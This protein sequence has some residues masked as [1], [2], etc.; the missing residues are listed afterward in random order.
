MLNLLIH[1][2]VL[3]FAGAFSPV[4]ISVCI[5]LLSTG[6]PLS[7]AIAYVL[8]LVF[9]LIVVGGLALVLF[10]EPLMLAGPHRGIGPGLSIALGGLCMVAALRTYLHV[11]DPDAPPP[12]WLETIHSIVPSRAFVFGIVLMATNL[13][14]L[15]I[16]TIGVSQILGAGLS[17]AASLIILLVFVL[18]IQL[19]VLMPLFIYLWNPQ[20][21]SEA[22]T[23]M[24]VKLEHAYR[25]VM[26]VL[27]AAIG[28][29]LIANGLMKT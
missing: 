21:A 22:L 9:S 7:N 19:G 10:D 13:K 15:V 2:S 12:K 3:A 24:R 16:Y 4:L 14:I 27:F 18:V 17:R 29:Y 28:C 20:G 6:H 1:L 23:N 8:G 11:P 5:L 26:I 25:W